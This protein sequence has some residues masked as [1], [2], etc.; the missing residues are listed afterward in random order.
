MTFAGHLPS[1]S[2]KVYA[3]GDLLNEVYVTDI[4][5]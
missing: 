2:K 4:Q 3:F 5:N 1:E